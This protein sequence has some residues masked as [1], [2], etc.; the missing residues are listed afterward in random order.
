MSSRKKVVDRSVIRLISCL[1]EIRLSS[2]SLSW[3]LVS[4][5]S[6]EASTS[7]TLL[8]GWTPLEVGWAPL[9]V[10][11]APLAVGGGE[12]RLAGG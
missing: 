11:C 12:M 9:E 2:S 10:C 5:C 1:A 8:V 7:T 6:R 3:M 4:S